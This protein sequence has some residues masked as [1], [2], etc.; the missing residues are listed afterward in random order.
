[1]HNHLSEVFLLDVVLNRAW[2]QVQ[3]EGVARLAERNP[4][5]VALASAYNDSDFED[6]KDVPAGSARAGR[7][8][9]ESMHPIGTRILRNGVRTA[10]YAAN[11]KV[12]LRFC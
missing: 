6:R 8:D 9:L 10:D 2:P 11:L 4:D 1:V 5:A 12:P 3:G 7:G